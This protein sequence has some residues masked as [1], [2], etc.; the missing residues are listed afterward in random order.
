MND[1]EEVIAI[2][3][4][5]A[6]DKRKYK[7]EKMMLRLNDKTTNLSPKVETAFN[8]KNSSGSSS[9][10]SN[11]NTSFSSFPS[12]DPNV[13]TT[14][15][16][17][18]LQCNI[19]LNI[20]NDQEYSEDLAKSHMI[21]PTVE[22]KKAFEDDEVTE[23]KN[24]EKVSEEKTP[25][26]KTEKKKD[27][28]KKADKKNSGTSSEEEEKKEFW[29]QS[30]RELLAKKQEEM[31]NA[32]QR[33]KTRTCFKCEFGYDR[34]ANDKGEEIPLKSLTT[35]DKKNFS[36]EQ[37]M[38][39]LIQSSIKDDIFASLEHDGSS[40]SVWEALRVKAEG[41]KQIKKN[42]IALLKKEF[43]LFDGL[44]GESVRQMIERFCHLKIVLD[45]F[46]IVKTREE[47]IDK[48]IEA[49]PRADQWQTFV[50]ILKND[51]LYE[52]ITLAVL[53]EK[54]ET[55][56]LELQKQNKMSSSS[57]QQ[58]VGLYYKGNVPQAIYHKNREESPRLK[59]IEDNPKKEKSR[60]CVVIQDDERFDWS[61]FLSE[62]DLVDDR[63]TAHGRTISSNIH[64]AFVAEIKERSRE[65]ILKEKTYRE[66]CIVGY[67]I[68]EMEK[69]YEEAIS[70]G[71]YDKKRECCVNRDGE[72]VVHK[73]EIVYEN[74]L[75]VIPLSGEFYSN[76]AK[77]KNYEKK[78]KKIVRDVMTVSLR[79]RDEERM[80]KN[81]ENLVDELKKV[82]EEKNVDEEKKA[83]EETVKDEYNLKKEEE[84]E[85][86]FE[87]SVKVNDGA[88]VGEEQQNRE[89]DQTKTEAKA[90]EPITKV[91]PK[92]TE[93]HQEECRSSLAQEEAAGPCDY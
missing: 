43:D 87:S 32:N 85:K 7:N 36:Y 8:A 22:G 49:L 46:G 24:A 3:D 25:E 13:S 60:A 78:L 20:E 53:I 34:P 69:E 54:T 71:R 35:D 57:H 86:K 52:T 66:R 70:N 28:K 4:M 72:P 26:K 92:K 84:A 45:R 91:L 41:G 17:K 1:D 82:A 83:E 5:S 30:N 38:I 29:R 27:I 56:E 73:K 11:N 59:Q 67:R 37:R 15:N 63:F 50:F 79:R 6:D 77:D 18:K 61:E 81:V 2:K 48:I 19:V 88:I 16:G 62:D 55:H 65:E 76:L 74:V 21:Y 14:R 89:V 23:E 44:K 68:E 40:K 90:E 51:V 42:K 93:C 31:K 10:G 64:R 39:A 33:K 75:A 9:K 58:N 80:K 12:F 47:I